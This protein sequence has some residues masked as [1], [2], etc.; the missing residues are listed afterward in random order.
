MS[1]FLWSFYSICNC[2]VALK[3]HN[4]LSLLY[5]SITECIQNIFKKNY[6]IYSHHCV[7]K[8]FVFLYFLTVRVFLFFRKLLNSSTYLLW[9]TKTKRFIFIFK[10]TYRYGL[11]NKTIAHVQLT[12]LSI[13]YKINKRITIQTKIYK[14]N[15]EIIQHARP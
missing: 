3:R 13:I 8:D 10:V 12:H 11:N 14:T 6:E 1:I 9:I 7:R 4:I 15:F 5:I 2:M